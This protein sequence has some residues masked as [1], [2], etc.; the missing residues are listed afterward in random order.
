VAKITI[1]SLFLSASSV[2][3]LS[4]I[5][6]SVGGSI[7][8][9]PVSSS[10]TVSFTTNDIQAVF[11]TTTSNIHSPG[12]GQKASRTGTNATITDSE[13]YLMAGDVVEMS[14]PEGAGSSSLARYS[15]SAVEEF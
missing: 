1:G 6:F 3:G 7:V 15:F 14:A 4:S 5:G 9:Q 11:G 8:A 12:D 13:F 2:G 10:G